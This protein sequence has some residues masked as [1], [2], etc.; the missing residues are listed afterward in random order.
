MKN[1]PEIFLL[2]CPAEIV[3]TN[4]WTIMDHVYSSW[5]VWP[6][7]QVGT[8]FYAVL[9]H[10]GSF[11]LFWD[12]EQSQSN[13]ARSPCLVENSEKDIFWDALF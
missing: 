11:K 13:W 7:R 4:S 2:I 8:I 12:T 6:F 10:L 5:S 9:F 3:G 1:V